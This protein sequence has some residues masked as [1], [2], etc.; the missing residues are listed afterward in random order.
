MDSIPLNWGK[1]PLILPILKMVKLCMGP[2]G[3]NNNFQNLKTHELFK[4]IHL[5]ACE[6]YF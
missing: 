6:N 2:Y 1:H 4:Q 3:M 5:L